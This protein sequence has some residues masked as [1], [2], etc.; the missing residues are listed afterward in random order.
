VIAYDDFLRVDVR[1]G[2]VFAA[3]PPAGPLY[4]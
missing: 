4:R 1:A 2:A 3:E